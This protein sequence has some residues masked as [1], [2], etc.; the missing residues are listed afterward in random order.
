MKSRK[1]LV[2]EEFTEFPSGRFRSEGKGSG[3]EFRDDFLIPALKDHDKVTVVF[4]GVFG[5][6]S[7]FLEEAFGGLRRKGFTEF[8]LT[9]K[10]EIISKDDF[11]LPAEINLFI[12]KK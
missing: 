7:S 11:S 9:H 4:D 2:A 6:A 10:L 1:I 5:T 12:R 8:Q 3:E